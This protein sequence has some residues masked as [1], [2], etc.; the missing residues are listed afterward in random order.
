M[1]GGYGIYQIWRTMVEK[2]K[3]MIKAFLAFSKLTLKTKF[4]RLSVRLTRKKEII[5]AFIALSRL[6]LKMALV[7][8]TLKLQEKKEIIGTFIAITGKKILAE[9]LLKMTFVELT[10]E[11]VY[12]KLTLKPGKKTGP[13]EFIILMGFLMSLIAFSIDAMLPALMVIGQD[14]QVKNANDAQLIVVFVFLGMGPGILFYGPISDSF[15]R[16]ASISL[17]LLIFIIGSFI[18]LFAS[19]FTIMLIGRFLQGFGVAGPRIIVLAIIRDRHQGRMLAKTIALAMMIFMIIPTIAP[20]IGFFITKFTN[21]RMI[22]VCFITVASICLFWLCLRQEETLTLEH[23]QKFSLSPILSNIGE[24]LKNRQLRNYSLAIGFIF[25]S[26]ISYLASSQQ[27]L[28]IQYQ[29]GEKFPF[30]SGS[31]ALT[32]ICASF[33]NSKLVMQFPLKH[34][35]MGT[36]AFLAGL[37]IIF[38]IYA[39]QF[40]GHPPLYSLMGFLGLALFCCGILLANLS[41][42]AIQPMGHIAGI[43]ITVC[44]FMQTV[45]GAMLGGIIAYIYD[46]TILPFVLGFVILS[47][48]ALWVIYRVPNAKSG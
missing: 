48:A 1:K 30:Y 28:E 40:H 43:A 15:G 21:W 39:L 11:I 19:N 42:L 33:C 25:A 41:A 34:L 17:G 5:K 37:S 6:T 27:I 10:L 26:F 3:A 44:G 38:F 29:L 20:T 47:L 4:V 45:I 46:N 18:S 8:F 31:L 23:K 24:S 12:T 9:F 16:K 2:E 32:L 13:I 7:N 36:I 14:L 35:C 22:F